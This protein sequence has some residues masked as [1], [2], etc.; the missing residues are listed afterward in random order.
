MRLEL[1]D[2]TLS[3]AGGIPLLLPIEAIDEDP[4]QP[5]REFDPEALRELAE[6]IVE[7]G[8]RQ[9]ISVRR[10]PQWPDRW[11]LNFGARRL[12][13]TRLAGKTDIPA[14]V[15]ETAD[16]Y[17]QVIENE[18]RE[19]LKPL[20]LALFIQRQLA[21]GQSRAEIA[22]RIGKS[23]PY[24]TYAC[25]LIDAPD[26][27]MNCYREARCHG[28]RELHELRRMHEIHPEE[29]KHFAST[30]SEIDRQAV[31]AFQSRLASTLSDSG[32]VPNS[33]TALPAGQHTPDAPRVRPSN[34]SRSDVV[35]R[36]EAVLSEVRHLI[37]DISA[38]SSDKGL[39]TLDAFCHEL[40]AIAQRGL[41]L[42]QSKR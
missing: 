28:I 1:L 42:L 5:R 37:D 11:M 12:R 17:D 2:P 29:T 22:R 3:P 39:A 40:V 6:T 30:C 36:S 7:R 4:G 13:A 19:A 14:F 26:W 23:R 21:G 18:Q 24:V 31:Q 38:S 35:S 41:S 27:L 10:H 15:D 25:A 33:F 8:V 20:E 16:S 9:P 32:A 34:S